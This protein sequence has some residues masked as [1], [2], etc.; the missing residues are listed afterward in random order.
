MTYYRDRKEYRDYYEEQQLVR[1]MRA[2]WVAFAAVFVLYA[3]HFW[4]LQVVRSGEYIELAE[5]NRLR[6]VA[7]QPLRGMIYDRHGR[8]MVKNRVSFNVLLN[9][10]KLGHDDVLLA[11]LSRDLEMEAAVLRERWRAHLKRPPFEP[12]ILK[13]D[14]DLAEV[15][16][17]EARREDFPEVSI[18]VEPKRQYPFG[19]AAAHLL[20][21]LGEVSEGDLERGE[22]SSDAG[23]G[24]LIGKAGAER[25]Y[26]ALLRGRKG[27][28]PVMV[29]SRGR[30]IRELDLESP[31]EPGENLTLTVDLDLQRELAAAYG[32]NVGAAVFLDARTS[33][34]LAL[35]SR[36]AYDPNDFATHFSAERWEALMGDRQHP[37]QNRAVQSK[38]SPGSTFKV[39][40]A[41]AALEEKTITPQTAYFCPGY[42][43][44]YRRTFKCH[45]QGG[46][47]RVDLHRALQHSCN[48]YF[49]QVGKEV[50]IEKI[51]DYARRLGY[52]PRTGIDLPHEEDGL[53]P[54]PEW[55][56]RVTGQ[57]WYPGE[58][59]SVAIGQGAVLITPVQMA[60]LMQRIATG[61]E[62]PAP[63]VRLA[64]APEGT[65]AGEP[66]RVRPESLRLVRAALRDVVNDW[67]T[68]GRARLADVEVCG[69]TGTVQVVAASAGIDSAKLAKE[70]RD[71]SWFA[72]WAP[73]AEP[74]VA[75]AVFVEHG[76][77]GGD[78][79]APIAK[80]VLEVYFNKRKAQKELQ[81]MGMPG[82]GGARGVQVAQ[83]QRPP[84][85]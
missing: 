77:H 68:G 42:V 13:E 30:L 18:G 37:L 64:D 65:S 62:P 27:L 10:D 82:G 1:R 22:A 79:A 17:L 59:V 19:T 47:G 9:R 32:D 44:L 33:E 24:D 11:S 23:L 69:K 34:V 70:V 25:A 43:V 50:G 4:Y 45:K 52:G 31:P 74:Q 81:A 55:K 85:P 6:Y 20:G 57:P 28:R 75:F 21:Y 5:N 35:E 29:N 15:A 12:V 3:G 60:R 41:I 80:R 76:G 53:M 51:A 36:P 16:F 66:V 8:L 71:H 78:S 14:V 58:T 63:Y 83:G 67:G 54:D 49:Y 7:V 73:C 84:A 72:G 40:V 2:V 39:V 56:Q 38:Y 61:V 46:H 48:V 26:D